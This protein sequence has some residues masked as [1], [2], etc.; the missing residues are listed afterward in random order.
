MEENIIYFENELED[1]FSKAKITPIKIDENYKYIRDSLIGKILHV[2]WLRI[3]FYPF[4]K[5]YLKLKFKHKIINKKILKEEKKNGYFLYG[6]HTQDT[7]DAF[8]PAIINTT[9]DTYV[10]VHPNNVSMKFLGKITPYL[11]A[12]PL[13]DTIGASKNF[14]KA[15]KKR[16]DENKCIMIYPEAHIWPYYTGIR[17][18]KDT[19]FRYPVDYNK[20]VFC[21]TNVY[22]KKKNKIVIETYIDGPFIP[23]LTLPKNIARA[24]LKEEVYNKMKERSK[25]SDYS[26]YKYLKKGD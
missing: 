26:K 17:N 24:K 18:F 7:A 14:V 12:L 15:I 22:H 3:I 9:L 11:G 16:C 20:K 5:I 2:F 1:E 19:S 23:D 10:I 25:L 4:A 8:I 21:F 6:N 13:P